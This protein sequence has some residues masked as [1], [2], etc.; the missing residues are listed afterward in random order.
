MLAF[1]AVSWSQN[2]TISARVADLETDERLGFASVGIKGVPIGTISNVNGEFDFHF[3]ADHRN[4]ILVISMMGY[5]NYE[6]PIW[7]LIDNNVN[8]IRLEKSSI[9]L[10]EIVVSDTLSGGDI[11]RIALSRVEEIYQMQPFLMVGFYRDV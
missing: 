8:V 7:T 4:D 9:Q 10:Q 1:P 2:L 6:A 11:L 5:K 3:P